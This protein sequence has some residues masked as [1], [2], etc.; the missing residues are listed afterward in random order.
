MG[1]RRKG[2]ASIAKKQDWAEWLSSVAEL[3]QLAGLPHSVLESEEAWWYFVD[4][5]YS[6]AGYLS[7][8]LWFDYEAMYPPQRDA[9][10]KLLSRWLKDRWPDA[11][12]DKLRSLQRTYEQ[13]PN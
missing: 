9:F 7:R 11:P 2:K 13:K 4:R 1:F 5:T 6:Q 10:W 3:V 12:Q 8:E